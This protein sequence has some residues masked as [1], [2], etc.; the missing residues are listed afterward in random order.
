MESRAGARKLQSRENFVQFAHGCD[1]SHLSFLSTLDQF[2]IHNSFRGGLTVVDI[3][4][5]M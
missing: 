5:M 4:D 1:L 2:L 3:P